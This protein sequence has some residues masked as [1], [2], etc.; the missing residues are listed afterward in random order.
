MFLFNILSGIFRG[1][2]DS[3]SPVIYLIISNV[4]NIGLLVLFVFGLKMGIE[5]AAWATVSAQL[6]AA[7]TTLIHLIIKQKDYDIQLRGC[8]LNWTLGRRILDIGMP[9]GLQTSIFSVG[10]LLQQNLINQFGSEIGRAH[11]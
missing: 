1:I 2:G 7:V 11:V 6:I 9:A 4:V 8:R 5:G 3:S 10:F